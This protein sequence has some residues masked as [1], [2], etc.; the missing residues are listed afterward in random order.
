MKNIIIKKPAIF[1]LKSLI[2]TAGDFDYIMLL[3][4]EE[5]SDKYFPF[6]YRD[7]NGVWVEQSDFELSD[8]TFGFEL[9]IYII[10]TAPSNR[11]SE[12]N[13]LDKS[14]NNTDYFNK[15]VTPDE[16][17]DE[18]HCLAVKKEEKVTFI[19]TGFYYDCNP[20]RGETSPLYTLAS[21]D[22]MDAIEKEDMVTIQT[23]SNL[24]FSAYNDAAKIW[25]KLQ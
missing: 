7:G 6:K 25:I 10:H 4:E 21:W 3:C 19:K 14:F 11:T 1:V 12:I 2:S 20:E 15:I 13:L 8:K 24:F 17:C 18:I 22:T 9:P 16:M 5:L 23:D